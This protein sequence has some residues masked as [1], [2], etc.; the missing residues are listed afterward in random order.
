MATALHMSPK[1]VEV[2]LTRV[3]RKLGIRSR[4]EL[5]TIVGSGRL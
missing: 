2:H 3:Y 1:T 4:G 5:G